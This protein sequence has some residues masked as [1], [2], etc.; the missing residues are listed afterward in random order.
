MRHCSGFYSPLGTGEAMPPSMFPG[1]TSAV[2]HVL[3]G[4][5]RRPEHLPRDSDNAMS[6]GGT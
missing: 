4:Y 2:N 1:G 5:I 3:N 6:E